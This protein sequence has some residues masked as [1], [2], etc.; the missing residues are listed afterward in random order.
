MG[1]VVGQAASRGST[2]ARTSSRTASRC[3]GTPCA[4]PPRSPRWPGGSGRRRGPGAARRR[5]Q[6]PGSSGRSSTT[7]IT[8]RARACVGREARVHLDESGP[9]ARPLVGIGDPSSCGDSGAADLDLDDGVGEQVQVPGRVL[10]HAAARR[11]DDE[12]LAIVDEQ[13]R[14]APA[15][16]TAPAGG[17]QQ[18]DRRAARHVAGDPT[19]GQAVHGDAHRR[20]PL[21]ADPADAGLERRHRRRVGPVGHRATRS[22]ARGLARLTAPLVRSLE[23]SLGSPRHSFARSRTRSAHLAAPR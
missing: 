11:N 6:R 10:V 15:A 21:D 22:L 9:Q 20:H 14:H 19:S 5:L 3:G 2:T 17:R 23:D 12:V 16:A 7:G 13:Q 8:R 1:A 4:T 18:A